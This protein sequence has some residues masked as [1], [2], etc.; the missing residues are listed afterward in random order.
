VTA[1]STI[2]CTYPDNKYYFQTDFRILIFHFSLQTAEDDDLRKIKAFPT[3]QFYKAESDTQ[4]FP[5]DADDLLR[6]WHETGLIGVH[7]EIVEAALRAIS[8]SPGTL[9]MI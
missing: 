2:C 5:S 4:Y 9:S 7:F 3:T 8:P 1:R 6:P